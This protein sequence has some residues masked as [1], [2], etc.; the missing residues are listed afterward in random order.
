MKKLALLPNS[1]QHHQQIL[2]GTTGR[3]TGHAYEVYLADQIN[4]LP[5]PFNIST[6]QLPTVSSCTNV[7]STHNEAF[8]LINYLAKSYNITQITRFYAVATGG[9]ATSAN[10]QGVSFNGQLIKKCKSDILIEIEDQFNNIYRMGIS[11]KQCNNSRPT[12]AQVFCTTA[13][14][15]SNL[16]RQY[17]IPVSIKAEEE[18]RKFCGHPGSSPIDHNIHLT[19]EID[20]RRYFWEELDIN[21]SQEWQYIFDNYNA[22]IA[23]ILLQKAYSNEPYPPEFLLHKTKKTAGNQ[24][25]AIFEIAD[26][27][28]KSFQYQNFTTSLYRVKKGAFKEPKTLGDTHEAPSFGIFQMQR[29]G[30]TQNAHQ[31]QFNLKAGY[32]Y[33]I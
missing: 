33:H 29:L 6:Q 27:I 2:A 24:E 19:R 9:L 11:V 15:F 1:T 12:N 32:F 21:A 31:L 26:L 25:I 8:T 7:F 28:V 4:K 17:N 30:N 10:S 20:H 16:L 3:N 5:V 13:T 18:L 14:G 23:R 22:D